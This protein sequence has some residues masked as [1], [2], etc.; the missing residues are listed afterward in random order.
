MVDE[1]RRL[2]QDAIAD[3]SS[4]DNN[5]V[6]QALRMA[7]DSMGRMADKEDERNRQ[8]AAMGETLH[9]IDKRLDRL[10]TGGVGTRVDDHE[11][12]IVALEKASLKREGAISAGEFLLKHW[13]ALVAIATA[14]YLLV[15][16]GAINV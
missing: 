11:K 7:A 4:V 10:E 5:I 1:H 12:R 16:S 8:L 3:P 2:L 13:P 15:K 6:L 9:T 14:F